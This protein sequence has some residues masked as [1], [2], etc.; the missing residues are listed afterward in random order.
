MYSV[1]VANL[2]RGI[3][4]DPQNHSILHPWK[5]IYIE[6]IYKGL[7]I[8]HVSLEP[9]GLHLLFSPL[10]RSSTAGG[11]NSAAFGVVMP[12]YQVGHLV[13]CI[14]NESNEWCEP[15]SSETFLATFFG[16]G[17]GHIFDIWACLKYGTSTHP[18]VYH[19]YPIITSIQMAIWGYIYHSIP[20]FQTHSPI[21]YPL[22]IPHY[23]PHMF[24]VLR[25]SVAHTAP[26]SRRS[27]DH[28][29]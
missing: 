8:D 3:P 29:N 22:Y 16:M 26:L 5:G 19:H 17:A 1:T 4:K 18:L 23:I 21:C 25:R 27:E 9:L 12:D 11:Q 6:S 28:P 14:R 13:S 15:H 20:H 2:Y 10:V 24:L 7:F